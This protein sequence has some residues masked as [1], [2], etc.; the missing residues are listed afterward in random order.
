MSIRLET[1]PAFSPI[2]SG[3]TVSG[4]SHSMTTPTNVGR[5]DFMSIIIA[6]T[7]GVSLNTPAGWTRLNGASTTLAVFY[8]R[9]NPTSPTVVTSGS[10]TTT[11][12]V[13]GT[14]AIADDTVAPVMS[15][16]SSG[17][18]A[19]PDPPSLASGL[20]Y[21]EI[22]YLACYVATAGTATQT[23]PPANYVHDVGFEVSAAGLTVSGARRSLHA[24]T[25]DA[26]AFT[27]TGSCTWQAFTI[28]FPGFDYLAAPYVAEGSLA[29]SFNQLDCDLVPTF[30]YK[31]STAQTLVLSDSRGAGFLFW[32]GTYGS[33]TTEDVHERSSPAPIRTHLTLTNKDPLPGATAAPFGLSDT[34][35][36]VTTFGYS[37]LRY[38]DS[39]GDDGLALRS[40]SLKTWREGI[41]TGMTFALTSV[42]RY[43]GATTYTAQKI[44][45][46]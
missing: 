37:D 21:R 19:A 36:N 43:T 33:A 7:G 11:S 9:G 8:R 14:I 22:L 23:A 3:S 28:A 30:P 18:S 35:D 42:A 29:V 12:W 5:N 44:T 34:P 46:Q 26:G 15:T 17:V 27:T 31:I 38:M 40:G 16:V 41:W 20:G 25:E 32:T 10:A 2:A 6:V 1:K 13:A 45:T 24:Q 39:F 4:T